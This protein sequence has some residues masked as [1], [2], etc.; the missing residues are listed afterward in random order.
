SLEAKFNKFI[1]D[2]KNTIAQY[3][4]VGRIAQTDRTKM[5][6]D[7]AKGAGGYIGAFLLSTTQTISTI[8]Q[9]PIYLFLLLIHKN[10]FK[11]FFAS[12]LPDNAREFTWKEEIESVIQGY[13][14]G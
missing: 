3:V 7:I 4:D 14:R 2:V 6:T 10:K 1:N 5:A 13:I 12:L 8:V 11:Q 9:I